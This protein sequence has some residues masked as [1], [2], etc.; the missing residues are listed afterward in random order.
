MKTEI[1]LESKFLQFANE[2]EALNKEEMK[3]IAGGAYSGT[4]SG[5]GG[6]GSLGRGASVRDNTY[7]SSPTVIINQSTNTGSGSN[8]GSQ[9]IW[10]AFDVDGYDYPWFN[11]FGCDGDGY[12]P[13]TETGKMLKSTLNYVGVNTEGRAGCY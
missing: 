3:I 5:G 9:N 6:G 7:V 8:S 10:A 12:H 1:K 13:T 11:D 4:S 2:L